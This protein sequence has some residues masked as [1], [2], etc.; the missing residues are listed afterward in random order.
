MV[1][2]KKGWRKIAL[3]SQMHVSDLRNQLDSREFVDQSSLCSL[4][5]GMICASACRRMAS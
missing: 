4:R 2:T 5:A 3:G 1:V